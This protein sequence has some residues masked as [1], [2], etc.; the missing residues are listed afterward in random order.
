MWH[1]YISDN[2]N[3]LEIAVSYSETLWPW[4][5]YLAVT[6]S[7]S[8]KAREFDGI[9]GGHIELTIESDSSIDADRLSSTLR[10]PIRVKEGLINTVGR[11]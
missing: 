5:G 2:G 7:V 4:S 8:E 1:P 10:L 6:I 9:I 3:L 11:L